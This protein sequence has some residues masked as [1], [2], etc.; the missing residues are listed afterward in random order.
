MKSNYIFPKLTETDFVLCRIMLEGGD[1]E[2][3][4]TILGLSRRYLY[5]RKKMKQARYYSD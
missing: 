1:E 5:E 4:A 2:Y 3:T